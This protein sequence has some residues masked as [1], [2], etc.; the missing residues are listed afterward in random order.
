MVFPQMVVPPK[1][2][3]MIIFSRKN[4]WL[5]GN[6]QHF[7]KPPYYIGI[8]WVVAYHFR[9]VPLLSPGK[10]LQDAGGF[11]YSNGFWIDTL[12]VQKDEFR[13]FR[14]WLVLVGSLG[15]QSPPENGNGT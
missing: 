7:R 12:T 10:S 2:P 5:L 14:V 4:P 1:H 9:G 8:V 11:K 13:M 6:Y 3:K 15:I